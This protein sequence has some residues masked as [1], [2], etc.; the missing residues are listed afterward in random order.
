MTVYLVISQ[1]EIPYIHRV[2]MVLANPTINPNISYPRT[3][4]LANYA[5]LR[6]IFLARIAALL[7]APP[8]SSAAPL[9]VRLGMPAA[10]PPE[11][12]FDLAVL[13]GELHF[14]PPLAL[15]PA[16]ESTRTHK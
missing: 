13:R 2:Y 4:H 5:P 10:L 14:L 11:A 7:G 12:R 16:Y 6:H 9:R 3:Q 15:L 1:P 8:A